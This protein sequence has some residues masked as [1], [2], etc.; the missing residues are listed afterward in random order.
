MGAACG[1]AWLLTGCA[2]TQAAPPQRYSGFLDDY[3]VLSPREGSDG[4]ALRYR[5]PGARLGSYEQLIIDPVVVYYGVGSGL[6][7]IPQQDLETL[8]NHLYSALVSQLGADYPLVQR[9]GPDVLRIQVALTEAKPSDVAMNTV[10]SAL[11][12]RPI[13]DAK[14]LATGTQAFVGTAGVEAKILDSAS[15]RLLAA[16]V[17]RRQGG[18]R[19][20]DA[21]G[22]WADVL[23]AFDYWARQLRQVLAEAREQEAASG[24]P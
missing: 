3:S 22:G 12:I 2:S 15:G 8:A 10:S 14:Q 21:Q 4:A 18:K 16:A 9:P 13:S 24:A 1:L 5:R 20:E 6:H 7:D 11:P 19:L 23:A 17:D